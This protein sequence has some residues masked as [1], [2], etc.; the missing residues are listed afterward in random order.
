[1]SPSIQISPILWIPVPL[2][3]HLKDDFFPFYLIGTS[4]VHWLPS[5]CCVPSRVQL[6]LFHI[7]QPGSCRQPK[8]LPSLLFA[9][10]SR[11]TS[12]PLLEGP[13]LQLPDQ[14]GEPQ[15]THFGT[16]MFFL[17]QGAQNWTGH[18][19][20]SLTSGKQSG[21]SFPDTCS[22]TLTDTAQEAVDLLCSKNTLL[23]HVHF[24]VH[25]IFFYRVAFQVFS[26]SVVILC[27]VI[28][29][30]VKDICLGLVCIC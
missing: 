18:S 22:N 8:A 16:S 28:S 30:L 7:I 29:A 10:L 19:R 5:H 2:F 17:Y 15:C 26:L 6:H 3:Y 14:P 20:C 25:H 9:R 21:R 27:G 11:W 1:M 23:T 4:Q 12:Q 24:V 13:V